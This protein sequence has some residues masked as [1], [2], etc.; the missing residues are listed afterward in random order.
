MKTQLFKAK[1]MKS[2]I[3]LVNNQFGEN[4]VILSTRKNNGVVEVEASDSDDAIHKHQEKI[5]EKESFSKVFMKEIKNK[6]DNISFIGKENKEN[7]LNDQKI[8]V[9]EK[10]RNEIT[11]LRDDLSRMVLTDQTGISDELSYLTPIKLRQEKFLPELINQLSYSFIGKNSEDGRISFFREL[12]RKLSSN[13]ITRMINSKNIFIFG[14]SGSGKS[15]LSAKIASYLSDKKSTKE[16]NFIDV[17][18]SGSTHSDVLRSYSRVLGFPIKD[19]KYFDF[20]ENKNSDNSKINIFDFS[21]DLNFSL[22][23]IKE[24][25][26]SFPSFQFCSILALPSGSNSEMIKGLCDNISEVR[27]MVAITKLDE[28]WVGAEEFSSLALNKARIGLVTGTKVIINSVIEANEN[29]LTKYM[30]ENFKGV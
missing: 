19:H 13:D 12:S 7:F 2:A 24:I 27:P 10:I 25:K 20:N 4:A 18:G 21:G 22:Q 11:S 1:D 29:S 8:D 26:N 28:C 30:K 9:Y 17:S 16:I 6:S 5:K 15:T 23:K 3:N 14:N